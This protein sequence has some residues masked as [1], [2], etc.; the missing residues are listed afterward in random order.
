MDFSKPKERETTT[1]LEDELVN[2]NFDEEICSD[3]T[4]MFFKDIEKNLVK[5]Q[6]VEKEILLYCYKCRGTEFS[7]N[8][9]PLSDKRF[10][11]KCHTCKTINIVQA[12]NILGIRAEAVTENIKTA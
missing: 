2:N 4:G 12:K 10:S 6:K 3:L 8:L 5:T 7:K 9:K 11:A 1:I